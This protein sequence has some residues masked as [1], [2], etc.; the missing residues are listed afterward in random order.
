MERK[1]DDIIQAFR[2]HQFENSLKLIVDMEKKR[3]KKG[4]K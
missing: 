1:I 4:K 2:E 3:E